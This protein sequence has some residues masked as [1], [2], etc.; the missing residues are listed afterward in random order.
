V[1][2][3]LHVDKSLVVVSKTDIHLTEQGTLPAARTQDGNILP[4]VGVNLL[5]GASAEV[6][7][8]ALGQLVATQFGGNRQAAL[9][10]RQRHRD[11]IEETVAHLQR[12]LQ[13][14]TAPQAA[15]RSELLAQ[16]LR[17]AAAALGRTTGRTGTEDVLDVV[18]SSFC[19]GK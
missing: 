3:Y 11:C 15:S 10:T 2:V 9:I 7:R 17:D 1:S 14:L 6:I 5:D 4:T 8:Q 12:A 18:F 13:V 16:D 19:I